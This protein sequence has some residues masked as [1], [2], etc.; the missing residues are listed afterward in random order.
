M[1]KQGNS[2]TPVKGAPMA[3]LKGGSM[4]SSMMMPKG[5]GAKSTTFAADASESNKGFGDDIHCLNWL[6]EIGLPQYEETFST[7]LSVGGDLLSRKRLSQIRLQDFPRMNIT[8][9]EH[10]KRL[11]EHIRHTL[12]FAYKSPIRKKEVSEK[13]PDAINK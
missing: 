7:N 1:Y 6:E 13:F 2:T 9:Y 5:M 4:M 12:Q 3:S 11:L 8:N 10:Q